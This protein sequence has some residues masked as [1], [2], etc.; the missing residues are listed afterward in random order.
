MKVK[1]QFKFI[2]WGFYFRSLIYEWLPSTVERF[3]PTLHIKFSF[4]LILLTCTCNFRGKISYS[5][6]YFIKQIREQNWS[7]SRRYTQKDTQTHRHVDT[8]T[9]RRTDTQTHRHTGTQTHRRTQTYT[10]K[11]SQTHNHW[12]NR[13]TQRKFK[14]IH[15]HK[16]CLCTLLTLQPSIIVPNTKEQSSIRDEIEWSFKNKLFRMSS[17]I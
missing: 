12:Q 14:D 6:I 11:D 5:L 8:Q 15:K 4:W 10:D 9:H 1:R 7:S 16:T 2:S 13:S 17:Y 3:K